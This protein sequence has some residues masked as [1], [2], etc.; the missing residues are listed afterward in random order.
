MV[1]GQRPFG[2]VALSWSGDLD[3]LGSG[4]GRPGG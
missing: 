4:L 1:L 3:E 2:P